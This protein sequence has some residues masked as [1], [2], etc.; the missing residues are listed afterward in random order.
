MSDSPR[1]A[2]KLPLDQQQVRA[3]CHHPSG[4]FISFP[5]DAIEQQLGRDSSRWC[6]PTRTG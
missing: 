1:V 4:K 5:N 3:K 6:N 2:T